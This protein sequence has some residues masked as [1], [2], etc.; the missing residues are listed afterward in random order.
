MW[1]ST[2]WGFR[3]VIINFWLSYGHW[4][5][6]LS[7]E[8]MTP[9]NWMDSTQGVSLMG[10]AG[11]S[12]GRLRGSDR[13]WLVQPGVK[14]KEAEG[15]RVVDG[16]HIWA[17]G[18][19]EPGGMLICDWKGPVRTS[20]RKVRALSFNPHGSQLGNS[21][22][23]HLLIP[24]GWSRASTHAANHLAIPIQSSRGRP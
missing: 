8:K 10:T 21:L 17:G 9:R 6:R 23:W 16:T 22:T 1:T 24:C 11:Q 2:Q 4:G 13:F 5:E 12:N 20:Q 14:G 19:D 18:G 15:F 7:Q 3:D